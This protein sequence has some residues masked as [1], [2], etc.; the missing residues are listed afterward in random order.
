MQKPMAYTILP[1][2]LALLAGCGKKLAEGEA[3]TSGITP[4]ELPTGISLEA[5]IAEDGS[6]KTGTFLVERDGHLYLPAYIDVTEGSALNHNIKIYLNKSGNI[7]EFHC[8]YR[9]GVANRYT[10]RGCYDL[11]NRDLGLNTS[12]IELF[13]F[14]IDEG[15]RIEMSM[16]SAPARTPTTARTNLRVDW[17]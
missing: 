1:L 3:A 7:W 14:P 15:K 2:T 11:D 10:L 12:N 5:S 6:R 4:I 9:G 16:L 13:T 8:N 17:K